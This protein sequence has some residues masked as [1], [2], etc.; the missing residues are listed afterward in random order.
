MEDS[1]FNIGN[2]VECSSFLGTPAPY[3]KGV[4]VDYRKSNNWVVFRIF[5]GAHGWNNWKGEI[6][7]LGFW[8]A[9][10]CDVTLVKR[11]NAQLELDF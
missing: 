4:V 10:G 3:R 7:P 1:L 11:K 8:G 6:A 5:K 9:S 2:I